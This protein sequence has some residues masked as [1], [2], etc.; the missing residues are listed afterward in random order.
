MQYSGAATNSSNYT[1]TGNTTLAGTLTATAFYVA[2]QVGVTT[3]STSLLLQNVDRG[4]L[5]N[6]NGDLIAS[7]AYPQN[8]GSSSTYWQNLYCQNIFMALTGS[9]Y[10]VTS[11]VGIDN[12]TGQLVQITDLATGTFV[13]GD[14][15][16]VH[17]SNGAIWTF[18][19]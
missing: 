5:L 18:S 16:T 6:T 14:S 15:N 8:L 4:V 9:S 1:L 10:S 3:S 13:D 11:P 2:S 17:V 19:L 12:V 7:S